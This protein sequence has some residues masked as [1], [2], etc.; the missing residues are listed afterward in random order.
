MQLRVSE[1]SCPCYRVLRTVYA[2][3]GRNSTWDVF[4]RGLWNSTFPHKFSGCTQVTVR[5]GQTQN[6]RKQLAAAIHQP[7]STNTVVDELMLIIFS[8]PSLVE[9][10]QNHTR[11]L[12]WKACKRNECCCETSGSMSWT[13]SSVVHRSA[14]GNVRF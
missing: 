9:P 6:L 14:C 2:Q 12:I 4:Y 8:A 13:Q 7:I 10:V 3:S 11:L 1:N 5:Y